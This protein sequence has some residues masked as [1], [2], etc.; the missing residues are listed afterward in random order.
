LKEEMQMWVMWMYS[1]GV[2]GDE[3]AGL[4]GV[5]AVVRV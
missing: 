3:G 4:A 5:E 2:V 1:A